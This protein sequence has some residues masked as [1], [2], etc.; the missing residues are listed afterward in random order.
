M[1][2]CSQHTEVARAQYL[3]IEKAGDPEQVVS[4]SDS[5]QIPTSKSSFKSNNKFWKL[6]QE[7]C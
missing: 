5:L 6:A 4:D 2:T 3:N 7:H 1:N